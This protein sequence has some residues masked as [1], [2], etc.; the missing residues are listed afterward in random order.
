MYI[1][2]THWRA[3][4]PKLPYFGLFHHIQLHSYE[5]ANYCDFSHLRQ[6]SLD[7]FAYSVAFLNVPG[8]FYLVTIL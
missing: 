8:P 7:R 5:P 6:S 1:L 2:G 4:L 3:H